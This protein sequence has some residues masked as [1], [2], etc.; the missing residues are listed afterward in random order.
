MHDPPNDANAREADCA[1]GDGTLGERARLVATFLHPTSI[2]I[3]GASAR[4]GS[5]SSRILENL[6]RADYE[7]DVYLVNPRYEELDGRPCHPDLLALP[8]VPDQIVVIVPAEHVVGITRTAVDMGVKSGVVFAG[9]FGEDGTPAGARRGED[10]KKLVHEGSMALCGPNCLGY[11]SYPARSVVITERQALPAP[12]NGGNIAFVAQSGGVAMNVNKQLLKNAAHPR[13][14]ISSGNELGLTIEDW[15]E[16]FLGD[17]EVD[18]IG[19]FIETVKNPQRFV[20][21]CSRARELG[22]PLVIT[23]VGS[24]PEARQATVSHTGRLAGSER[25]FTNI[26]SEFGVIIVRTIDEIIDTLSVF[27]PGKLPSSRRIAGV[28]V[29][30]GLRSIYLESAYHWDMKFPSLTTDTLNKMSGYLG[31][32]TAVGNPVDSGWSGLADERVIADCV[33]DIAQDSETSAV[34]LQGVPSLSLLPRLEEISSSS[35][36]LVVVTGSGFASSELSETAR[37]SLVQMEGIAFCSSGDRAIAALSRFAGVND[38]SHLAQGP[39]RNGLSGV[40]TVAG[41]GRVLDE[42]EAKILIQSFGISVPNRVLVETSERLQECIGMIGYPAILKVVS[43]AVPHKAE[44]GLISP[45]LLSRESAKDSFETLNERCCQVLPRG[46]EYQIWLEEVI[47]GGVECAVG[48]TQ[49]K[50]LGQVM[51]FGLGGLHLELSEDVGFAFPVGNST[52]ARHLVE[53]TKIGRFLLASDRYDVEALL[54]ALVQVGRLARDP[55]LQLLSLDI[56]PIMVRPL[57]SGAT[58]LDASIVALVE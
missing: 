35:G 17:P 4:R 47:L 48:L 56:N 54:E 14:I 16:Y 1:S 6:K 2:A 50:E 8:K 23:K 43:D 53:R 12:K 51:M 26:C 40:S 37:Q 5:W 44:L 31:V 19:T 18:I 24:S 33:Q 10:F 38:D 42:N 29:S 46:A 20:T 34:L 36:K 22:K 9:G 7:G 25:V 49:D 11:S 41:E 30:G 15:L 57:G 13:Y 32:G 55:V 45:F 52:E 39:V 3:V 58:V 28:T 27:R 21:L